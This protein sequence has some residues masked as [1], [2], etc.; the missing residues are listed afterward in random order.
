M[1]ALLVGCGSPTAP[2]PP[3]GPI[4][5]P[6]VVTTTPVK[7]ALAG[8]CIGPTCFTSPAG[9]R[10]VHPLPVGETLRKVVVTPSGEVWIAGDH[11]TL[12]DGSD[13]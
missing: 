2:A 11:A 3:V 6:T 8:E 7:A 5:T 13:G 9:F 1:L 12:L 4:T 10:F